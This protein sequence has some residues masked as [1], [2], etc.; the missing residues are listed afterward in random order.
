MPQVD[1]NIEAFNGGELSPRISGRLSLPVYKSGSNIIENLIPNMSGALERRP[2]TVYVAPAT[3]A[4]GSNSN[5]FTSNGSWLIPFHV[6]TGSSYMIELSDYKMRFYRDG[7]V[8]LHTQPSFSEANVNATAN[9]FEIPA[10]G[11]KHGQRVTYHNNVGATAPN[12]LTDGTVYTVCLPEALRCVDPA[13]ATGV[14]TAEGAQ[15]FNLAVGMGPYTVKHR[16]QFDMDVAVPL[17]IQAA[18]STTTCIFSLSKGGSAITPTTSSKVNN[19]IIPTLEAQID[20]FRLSSSLNESEDKIKQSI[21]TFSDT[22]TGGGWFSVVGDPPVEIDTPWSYEQATTLQWTSE[23]DTMFFF[24]DEDGIPP[25]ELLRYGNATFILQR[26]QFTGGPL[27]PTEPFGEAVTS[28]GSVSNASNVQLDALVIWT[29]TTGVFRGSD[30]GRPIRKEFDTADPLKYV[31]GIIERLETE[32]TSFVVREKESISSTS[33][34]IAVAAAPAF[35]ADDLIWVQPSHDPDHVFPPEL[36]H[37]TPYYCIV[38]DATHIKLSRTP[39][40]SEVTFSDETGG[41]RLIFGDLQAVADDLYT[42]LVAHPFVNGTQDA[43]IWCDGCSPQGLI[44]GHSY[45]VL[46]MGTNY[47]RLTEPDGTLVPILSAGQG[48]FYCSATA[49]AST[50]A[51]VRLLREPAIPNSAM[52]ET[53]KWRIGRWNSRDGWPGA[54]T[55]HREILVCAGT[56]IYPTTVWGSQ[57]AQ[58]RDFSPDSRTGSETLPSDQERTITEASGWSYILDNENTERVLWLHPSTLIVAGS[59]GPIHTIDG[60]TPTTVAASLMTTRGSSHVRPLVSDAQ[61]IWGSSKHEHVFAAGFQEKRQ[62]FVPDDITK[63]SDHIFTRKNN[64][65]QMAMQE[66]PWSL[67]WCVREDGQIATCT[68]DQEQGV[69]AWARHKIGG[70]HSTEAFDYITRLNKITTN[71]WAK[72]TSLASIPSSTGNTQEIWMVVERHPSNSNDPSQFFRSIERLEPRF[73][74]DDAKE[75]AVFVDCAAQPTDVSVDTTSFTVHDVLYEHT[76][77]AWIDG[78]KIAQPVSDSNG[79]IT[80]VEPATYK[81]VVG[82]PARWKWHS[83]SLES[84]LQDQPTLKGVTAEVTRAFFGLVNSLGGQAGSPGVNP[85]VF[86]FR[87]RAMP[88]DAGPPM[89]TGLH[90]VKGFPGN[91]SLTNIIEMNATGPEPFLLTNILARLNFHDVTEA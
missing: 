61:I 4:D 18:G 21:V 14:Y 40:G 34:S 60:L 49:D 32:Y 47:F 24:S 13:D 7:G 43:G 48:K 3:G 63:V 53:S 65:I 46:D 23:A 25:F 42:S 27:G 80:L 71:D 52:A 64:L 1:I 37:R 2:G 50:V 17:W 33:N 9:Q 54:A 78:A 10:H 19:C 73:E 36:G 69:Q 82:I 91:P 41:M 58:L 29:I 79:L 90:E 16:D 28:T 20:T 67:L 76:L 89:F 74:L 84:L 31:D 39:G 22:G 11:F 81:I 38:V 85:E 15:T 72:V 55:I 12:G 77:D 62:G 6:S 5:V 30:C 51:R 44:T 66:E 35:A 86:D 70:S 57:L 75:D 56:D 26:I 8:L 83:S 87:T 68:Y 45:Q 59:V 88:L